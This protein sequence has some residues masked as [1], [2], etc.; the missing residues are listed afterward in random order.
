MKNLSRIQWY[1]ML[2]SGILKLS[3]RLAEIYHLIECKSATG[4][5]GYNGI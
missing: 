2:L 3:E 4:K 5:D 1:S